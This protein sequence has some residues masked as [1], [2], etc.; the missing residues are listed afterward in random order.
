MAEALAG[1]AIAVNV[2]QV[3]AFSR[4]VILTIKR[5]YDNK[6]LA[7][8]ATTITQSLDKLTT[9]LRKDLTPAREQSQ[10][11]KELSKVADQVLDLANQIQRTYYQ[12]IQT[13]TCPESSLSHTRAQNTP[14][15]SYTA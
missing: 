7:P 6:S 13:P 9:S 14:P 12:Q 8:E 2:M 11:D 5:L 10:Q 3:I 15:P 4:D 1:L